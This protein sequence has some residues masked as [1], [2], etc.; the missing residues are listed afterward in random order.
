MRILAVSSSYPRYERDIAGRF[1]REM[2]LALEERGH[3]VE[4]AAWRGDSSSGE[5]ASSLESERVRRV[6]YGPESVESLFY[7]DGVVENLRRRPW[8]AA[9]IPG[10]I[11]AMFLRLVRRVR[12]W[13]PDLLVGHWLVPAGALVRLVGGALGVPSLTVAHS[14]GV[15]LLGRLPEPLKQ[16]IGGLFSGA[17]VVTT[18][19]PLRRKLRRMVPEVRCAVSPMGYPAG[20]EAAYTPD[21]HR[22]DL[23]FIGR[24][25]ELK[26]PAM[27]IEAGR[28]VLDRRSATLRMAGR[29][30]Q[31]RELR[32][33]ARAV[34]FDVEVR[35][36]VIGPEKRRLLSRSSAA[37]F[38][39]QRQGE[40]HEGLPV[41]LLEASAAGVVPFVGEIPGAEAV[42][43]D[44]SLQVVGG[45]DER[46]WRRRLRQFAELSEE[47]RRAL[48]SETRDQVRDLAWPR[49]I[50]EWERHLR[51]A[52]GAAGGAPLES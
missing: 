47:S 12:E 41:S 45:R 17:H 48:A 29:G 8:R 44:P 22:G 9:Q 26:G 23:L 15:H 51:N 33:R 49:A 43:A 38:P 30:P 36:P 37:L 13:D 27:A 21:E 24:F 11:G 14:G 25:V 2:H 16:A 18:S 1:V 40:R 32:E 46:E 10:A 39:S 34:E 31:E 3:D 4:V 20:L 42:L 52:A 35:E 19:R 6:A 7:G 28:G 50:E 5:A